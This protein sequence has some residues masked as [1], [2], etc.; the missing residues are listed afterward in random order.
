MPPEIPV[1]RRVRPL[2]A[3]ALAIA[4]SAAAAQAGAVDDGKRQALDEFIAAYRL[5]ELWPRMAPKIARDSLPRLEDAVRADID[6]DPLPTPE[7][8]A[9]A[10][11]SVQRL[12]PQGRRDLEAALQSF[13]AGELAVHAAVQV[14][15]K[16]FETAEIRQITAFFGSDTG[17]KL[18]NVAPALLA[19]SRKPGAGDV[20]PRHFSESELN[21]ITAFWNSPVGRKMNGTAD[22]VREDMHAHFIEKS[23]TA[24]QAVARAVA[25][26]AEADETPDPASP[27]A[28]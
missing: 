10:Q 3:L 1:P 14:Y 5:A 7:R 18:T 8:R 28:P 12:L 2:I 13:D 24:V 15:G 25:T 23:E 19:E 16:Y 22:L 11:A 27:A 21:D 9:A 6:A 26:R 4:A 17:R 20:M